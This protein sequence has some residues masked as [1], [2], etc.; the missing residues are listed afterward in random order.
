MAR[1]AKVRW[2]GKHGLQVY[3]LQH[4]GIAVERKGNVAQAA[5]GM[6]EV[7]SEACALKVVVV[8]EAIT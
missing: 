7:A 8:G 5:Q 6:S 4:D 3:Q 2:C 1:Q